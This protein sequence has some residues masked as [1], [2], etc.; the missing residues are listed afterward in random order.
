[1]ARVRPRPAAG[2]RSSER[3]PRE[4]VPRLRESRY[5]QSLER[6]LAILACFTPERPVWGISDLADELSMSRST[7]H[8][9]ALTLTALGYLVQDTHRKYLLGPRILGVGEGGAR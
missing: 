2:A 7:T 3:E 8:R 5:S 9:Y 6:G 4:T 1:M